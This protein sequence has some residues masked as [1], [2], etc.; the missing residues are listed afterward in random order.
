MMGSHGWLGKRFFY[1][2]SAKVPLSISFPGT[3]PS[4]KIIHSS[5][6]HLDLMAT[7]LDYAGI[8]EVD[9][10]DG[11]SLRDLI[12]GTSYNQHYDES[13]VVAQQAW[14]FKMELRVG[15][16]ADFMV[17][18]FNQKLI[19][20]R[21]ANVTLVDEYYDL[22]TD[23]KELHNKLGRNAGAVTDEVI[24]RCE[25]M[26]ILLLEWLERNDH[27]EGY[28]SDPAHLQ[29]LT[30]GDIAEVTKRRT[31]RTVDFWQST[32]ETLHF[33]AEPAYIDGKYL[34]NE[35]LYVGRTTP[36][37]F[38]VSVSVVGEDRNL[39]NVKRHWLFR[40]NGVDDAQYSRIQVSYSNPNKIDL[41]KIDARIVIVYNGDPVS[42]LE[43]VFLQKVFLS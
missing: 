41:S 15:N 33:H 34:R 28:Y 17:R 4:G 30:S 36:G 24:G 22:E 31:W 40:N 10:T 1:E 43:I 35:Y 37:P 25:H 23:P 8:S 27:E 19:V 5:V 21:V 20:P 18:H 6:S 7:L 11:T 39:F 26:K 42:E 32:H 13:A 9:D 2:E 14:G 38:K 12:E 29:H 3:I 16:T